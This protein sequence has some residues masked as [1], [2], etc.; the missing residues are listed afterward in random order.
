[1][2]S[3]KLN[4]KPNNEPIYDIIKR[5]K[6]HWNGKSKEER[7]KCG[8]KYMHFIK[9]FKLPYRT[10]DADFDS[11]SNSITGILLELVNSSK[12]KTKINLEDYSSS[13]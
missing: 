1:M 5:A 7:E 10:W 11:L 3:R 2:I 8:L 12:N 4:K 9:K 13:S 6:E